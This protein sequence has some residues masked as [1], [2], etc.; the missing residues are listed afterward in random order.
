[1]KTVFETGGPNPSKPGQQM[2]KV[3]QH[4]SKSTLFKVTY[5]HISRDH[6]T[7][8]QTCSAVGACIMHWQACGGIVDKEEL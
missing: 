6:L 3:E 8:D 2:I 5:G 7:Y 1:M 4:E